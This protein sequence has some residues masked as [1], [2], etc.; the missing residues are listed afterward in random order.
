M[1]IEGWHERV[2]A[3]QALTHYIVGERRLPRIRYGDESDDWRAD[4]IPCHDCAVV[5]GQLHVP[6]CD[7]EECPNCNGQA[8]SCDCALQ[9]SVT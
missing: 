4:I 7:V 2:A 6:D 3:A 9:P 5:K 8:I 1:P